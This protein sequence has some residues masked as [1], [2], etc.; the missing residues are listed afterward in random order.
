MKTFLARSDPI[1]KR[2][3]TYELIGKTDPGILSLVSS[4][5]DG[6]DRMDKTD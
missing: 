3:I 4:R 1:M 5:T 2:D 6:T